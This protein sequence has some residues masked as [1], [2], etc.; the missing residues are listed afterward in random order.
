[1]SKLLIYS[2]FIGVGVSYLVMKKSAEKGNIVRAENAKTA[3]ILSFSIA[4]VGM[5]VK[6]WEQHKQLG[7]KLA[8][9]KNK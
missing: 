8:R 3:M 6:I 4:N 1:M 9:L 5:L 2:G 7:E